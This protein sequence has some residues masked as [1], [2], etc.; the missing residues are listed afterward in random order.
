LF[1]N[2]VAASTASAIT[3]AP[4]PKSGYSTISRSSGVSPADW[5]MA[6]IVIQPEPKRPGVPSR[7]PAR[8]AGVRIPDD[9]FAN[10]TDGNVP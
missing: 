2:P 10:T 3:A 6:W 7:L 4:C 8:S 9:A 1:A 5:S